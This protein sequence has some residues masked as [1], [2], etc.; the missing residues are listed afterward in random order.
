MEIFF[1]R[2]AKLLISSCLVIGM[3]ILQSFTL[4]LKAMPPHLED[5]LQKQE[6]LISQ[7]QFSLFFGVE[8]QLSAEQLKVYLEDIEKFTHKL[9]KRK[10]R[11]HSE[12]QFLQ[13]AFYR[14]HN[15]Y[16]KRYSEH[17]SLYD[18][19][20]KGQYD[21]ITGSAFYALILD[22]LE[23]DYVIKELPYH[24]YLMVQPKDENGPVLL[25]STDARS[26]YVEDPQRVQEMIKMYAEDIRAE[27]EDQYSYN[28]V[29]DEEIE[30]KQLAAL[31]Y[32]N[33]AVGY[34]NQQKLKQA[35]QY[36]DYATF[37]YPAKRMEALRM[38]IN[39]VAN[40]QLQQAGR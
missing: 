21:C 9:A 17:A 30:L 6:T 11:Y 2:H 13:Y 39:Q 35:T 40:R 15:R 14:I 8:P 24:V 31:N 28:F 37:L 36:L 1:I 19:L 18:L 4:D 7:E 38:L 22:A 23:V 32:Y 26:G 34:Y 5:T 20:D 33:E 12:K 27:G 10:A 16:M 25:E 3:G 29:I